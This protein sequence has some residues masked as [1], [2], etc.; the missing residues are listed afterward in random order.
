MG[1]STL[2]HAWSCREGTVFADDTVPFRVEGSTVS[3]TPIPFRI[4]ARPPAR[5][6]F[7]DPS[8][9]ETAMGERAP[10]ADRLDPAAFAGAP[11]R[12]IFLLRRRD[13]MGGPVGI[14]PVAPPEALPALL[15]HALCLHL[16]DR[17]RNAAMMSHYLALAG[18]VPAFQ[19]SYP[20]G[21]DHVRAILDRLTSH[22]EELDA[23]PR[24]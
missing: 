24:H 4:R 15:K 7:G 22:M 3:V 19:L 17:T 20:T 1:K 23:A 14:E 8:V 2:A 16:R 6:Y 5:D 11:L 9:P 10:A 13:E 18:G 12:A 21:L